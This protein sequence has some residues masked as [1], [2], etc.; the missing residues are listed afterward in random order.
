[1]LEF[2]RNLAGSTADATNDI[3]SGATNEINSAVGI[4][5]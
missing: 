4:A 5:A 2:F 1:M 3:D